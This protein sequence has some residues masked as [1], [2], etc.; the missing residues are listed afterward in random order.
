MASASLAQVHK[1]K[2]KGENVA[3]KVQHRG[4]HEQS[5]GDIRL[6]KICLEIVEW[7]FPGFKY[8]WLGD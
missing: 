3:V 5:M 7:L 2:L 1:A 6:V 4:L 8:K